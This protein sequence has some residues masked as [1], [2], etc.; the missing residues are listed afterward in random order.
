[1]TWNYRVIKRKYVH[2]D[3]S[4]EMSYGIYEAYYT[5]DDEI[6]YITA[7][8]VSPCGNSYKELIEDLKHYQMALMKPVL[9]YDEIMESMH[10]K[11][12]KITKTA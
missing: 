4:E 12:T 6:E 2:P 1:M 11:D 8:P 3:G 5:E 7:S 9:D 10:K